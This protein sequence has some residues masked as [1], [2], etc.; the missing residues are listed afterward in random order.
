MHKRVR[1]AFL[2]CLMSGMAMAGEVHVIQADNVT[3][4][5]RLMGQPLVRWDLEEPWDLT[6]LNMLGEYVPD[7]SEALP[8]TPDSPESAVLATIADPFLE[9]FFPGFSLEVIPAEALNVPLHEVGT[10]VAGDLSVRSALPFQDEDSDLAAFAQAG[11]SE[12]APL[13]VGDWLKASGTLRIWCGKD[14]TA[15]F[16]IKVRDM[17]PNRA[18]TAWAVWYRPDGTV[19][20]QPF[21]GTPNAWITNDRGDATLKRELNFCPTTAAREGIDGFR[22]LTIVTH[23][24]SDHILYGALPAP[25]GLGLPA[26]TVTHTQLMF[27][28]GNGTRLPV[29]KTD[30]SSIQRHDVD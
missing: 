16:E 15:K 19:G 28:L 25:T 2:F 26:G 5:N 20:A 4:L 12:L 29:E 8:L 22:L 3:G 30:L 24:H 11:P 1:L 13:T 14:G 6:G 21:G 9:S 23:L 27:D 10:W 7:A 18:Y 17:V